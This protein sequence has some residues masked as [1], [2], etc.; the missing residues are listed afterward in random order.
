MPAPAPA[1][2]ARAAAPPPPQ[3]KLQPAVELAAADLAESNDDLDFITEHLTEAEVF[4][5]YGLAEKAAE[6]LRAVLE[7]APTNLTA[8]ER[9][10]KILLDEGDIDAARDAGLAFIDLLMQ[11]G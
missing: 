10:Y 3:Q 5:K 11:N 2:P 7:R 8:H 4:A 6:H 1:P 9:L